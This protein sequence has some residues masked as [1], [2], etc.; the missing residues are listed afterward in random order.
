MVLSL[1]QYCPGWGLAPEINR[2]ANA[3]R[4]RHGA[5]AVHLALS[6]LNDSIDRHDPSARDFWVQ[7]VRAIHEYDGSR[8]GQV[9]L[10]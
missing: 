5:A 7:V 9:K 10:F 3:L 2:E 8:K 4:E 6:R 1:R